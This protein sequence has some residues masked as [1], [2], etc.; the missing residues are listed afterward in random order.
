MI[1]SEEVLSFGGRQMITK[2]QCSL[3]YKYKLNASRKVSINYAIYKGT[4]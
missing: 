4:A 2:L 1:D 3:V